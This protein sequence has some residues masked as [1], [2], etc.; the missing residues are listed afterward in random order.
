VEEV[1]L[2]YMIKFEAP[3]SLLFGKEAVKMFFDQMF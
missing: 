1:D 3:R 2:R